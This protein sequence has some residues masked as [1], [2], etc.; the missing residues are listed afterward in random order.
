MTMPSRRARAWTTV[1]E[2]LFSTA[3]VDLDLYNKPLAHNIQLWTPEGDFILDGPTATRADIQ[4][5][6]K[7]VLDGGLF[8]Y[9]FRYPTMRVGKYK[10]F[11][12][13]PLAAYWSREDDEAKL[14]DVRLPGYFT[15]YDSEQ[16]DLAHPIELYPRLLER[17][18][19]LSALRHLDE[20]RDHYRHQTALNILTILDM[21]E[22]WH[23]PRLPRSFARQMLR[24]AKDERAAQLAGHRA[25][26][27][28]A[29]D[30]GTAPGAGDRA[31]GR[32]NRSAFARADHV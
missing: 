22:L 13:R 3:L 31:A 16:P 29:A 24:M 30:G 8:R 23:E 15:A 4:R 20:R 12:Q 7:D 5:A 21:S 28:H 10:V 18:A 2:A 17:P 9:F 1:T 27:S 14:L 11:W 19:Y 32:G 25:R 26:T 6:A